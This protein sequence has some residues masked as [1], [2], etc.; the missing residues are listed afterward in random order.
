MSIYGQF[1]PVAKATE[2]LGERWTLLLIRE[3]LCG[4]TRF[5]ELQRGLA[6]MSPSLLTKRLKELEQSGL[7]NKSK[8]SGQKG[9]EYH[10]TK[11]GQE[12]GPLVMEIAK[13]GMKWVTDKLSDDE[14]DI[15]LLMWDIHR[16]IDTAKLKQNRAVIKFFISDGEAL[17]DWWIL[18]DD[19]NVD[20]CNENPG[21]E[22]DLYVTAEARLLT[23]LWMGD[24]TWSQAQKS[25]SLSALGSQQLR[26]SMDDWL[27]ANSLAE[28]KPK[29]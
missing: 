25:G 20:I 24:L 11:A 12:L 2:V 14:L 23:D 1:C 22:P 6:K 10:L 8:I 21:H 18:I 4:S 26:D 5:S 16:N 9:Y 3:L 7:V 19:T 13:W 29:T 27:G 15:E 28:L 17:K